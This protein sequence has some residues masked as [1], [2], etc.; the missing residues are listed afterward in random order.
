M[1]ASDDL[2]SKRE[3]LRLL[4]ETSAEM[5]TQLDRQLR[6]LESTKANAKGYSQMVTEAKALAAKLGEVEK[7]MKDTA[8]AVGEVEEGLKQA[9]DRLDS[10]SSKIQDQVKKI[11]MVGD[12]FAKGIQEEFG[13]ATTSSYGKAG[14]S[15]PIRGVFGSSIGSTTTDIEYV[16]IMTTGNAVD[17]GNLLA[18][19]RRTSGLSNG[20]GGLG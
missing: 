17:F 16:Q 6:L 3:S 11:P 12:T 18:S 20:H 9:E 10:F 2:R 1:A 14:M 13:D 4:Q 7:E 5:N 8:N 15:S 19:R